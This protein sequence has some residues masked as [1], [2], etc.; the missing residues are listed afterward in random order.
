MAS[1][2][3]A[4]NRRRIQTGPPGELFGRESALGSKVIEPIPEGSRGLDGR[5]VELDGFGSGPS[6]FTLAVVQ[7][8]TGARASLLYNQRVRVV[9][10]DAVS[11]TCGAPSGSI[12]SL[13]RDAAVIH[14]IDSYHSEGR[15]AG[16][17]KTK[18]PPLPP[19]AARGSLPR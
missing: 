9:F 6:P 4:V 5:E 10:R 2:L 18:N 1:V 17:R 7:N 14:I 12:S 19:A 8:R 3:P 11:V 16:A 13:S 15:P